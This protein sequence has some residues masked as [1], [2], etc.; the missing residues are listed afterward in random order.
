MA[1]SRPTSGRNQR[2][3]S[4][5]Q[6][7]NEYGDQAIGGSNSPN[8]QRGA[9]LAEPRLGHEAGHGDELQGMDAQKVG[10]P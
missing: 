4:Q 1:A 2:Q 8:R 9:A 10:Y 5:R 3:P 6:M 7:E